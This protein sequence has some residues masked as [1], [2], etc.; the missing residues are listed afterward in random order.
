VSEIH[1]M[2]DERVGNTVNVP[3]GEYAGDATVPPGVRLIFAPGV[4]L[5]GSVTVHGGAHFDAGGLGWKPKHS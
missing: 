4:R 2:I 5:S 1:K 3:A